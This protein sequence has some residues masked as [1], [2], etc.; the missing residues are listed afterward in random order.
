MKRKLA[1][2]IAICLSFVWLVLL[3]SDSTIH[4]QPPEKYVWDTGVVPL[5]PNQVLRVTIGPDIQDVGGNVVFRVGRTTYTAGGCNSDGV[6]RLTGTNTFNGPIALMPG[7]AVSYELM[8]TTYGRGLVQSNSRNL[9]VRAAVIDPN[10]E[11]QA[12]LIALSLP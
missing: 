11:V 2:S 4:A 12:V 8:A 9:R 10:G 6:C 5:G 1:L 7:Q 3:S